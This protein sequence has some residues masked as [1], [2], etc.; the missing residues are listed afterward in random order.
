M[1]T[2][3]NQRFVPVVENL[4]GRQ[5]FAAGPTVLAHDAT[6]TLFT[7]NVGSG[8]T[9]TIGRTG[10]TLYDIAADRRGNVFGVD[11]RSSLYKINKTTAKAT[12]VGSVG[13]FVNAL[14][15]APNGDLLAA[16]RNQLVKINTGTG[17]GTVLGNLGGNTSSGDLAFDSSGRL[18]LSTTRNELVRV[19]S[20]RGGAT[21]VGAIG[22]RDV[23]GLVF[24]GGKLYGMSN[25]SERAFTISTSTGRGTQ[26]S[27]FGAK[28]RGLYGS[29]TLPSGMGASTSARP[30]ATAT[31]P[32]G[33][34]PIGSAGVVDLPATTRQA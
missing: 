15:F 19:N 5:L 13:T 4:E 7:L 21:R 24:A 12:R 30:G 14:T 22:F 10:V 18:F 28:V 1:K 17:R 31:N 11:S 33:T 26:T 2:H 16:G 3:S 20:A 6:G 27:F 9:H 29:T 25:S 32:F 8:Q 23:Y 34:K